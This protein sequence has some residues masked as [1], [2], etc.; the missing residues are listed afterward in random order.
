MLIGKHIQAARALTGH[1]AEELGDLLRTQHG[2]TKMNGRTLGK[3]ER[4][5]RAARADE[6]LAI[7]KAL[8]VPVSWLMEGPEWLAARKQHMGGYRASRWSVSAA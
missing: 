1:T 8:D 6:V 5:E 7:A 3:I 2:L 4:G